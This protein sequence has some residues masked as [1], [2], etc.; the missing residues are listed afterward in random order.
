M[1]PLETGSALDDHLSS[2]LFS[3]QIQAA[4]VLLNFSM[5]CPVSV[6][7]LWFSAMAFILSSQFP[8]FRRWPMPWRET[9]WT[10]HGS[11]QCHVPCPNTLATHIVDALAALEDIRVLQ[12]IVVAAVL[13]SSTWHT[14]PGRVISL[15]KNLFHH[16]QRQ[17]HQALPSIPLPAPDVS[18]CHISPGIQSWSPCF[19]P[20]PLIIYSQQSSQSDNLKIQSSG[21]F[22]GKK[23]QT[24]RTLHNTPHS[25][26]PCRCQPQPHWPPDWSWDT[27]SFLL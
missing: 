10:W 24:Y 9:W 20:Q 16:S 19:H 8:G 12:E 15:Y 27:R 6:K 13:I 26:V 22:E 17:N 25:P 2:R 14:A 4:L 3:A 11:P 18:P 1:P 23:K 21:G 5:C 7:L